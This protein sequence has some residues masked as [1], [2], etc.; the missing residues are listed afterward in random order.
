MTSHAVQVSTKMLIKV[1]DVEFQVAA[2]IVACVAPAALVWVMY[3]CVRAYF[4]KDDK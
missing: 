2:W 1:F 4:D 3:M